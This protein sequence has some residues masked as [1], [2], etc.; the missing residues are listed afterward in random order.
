MG[1]PGSITYFMATARMYFPFFSG[2]VKCSADALDVANRQNAHGM[3]VAVRALVELFRSVK[4]EKELDR[5]DAAEKS[6]CYQPGVVASAQKN[7][8]M[9]NAA[10]KRPGSSG[11]P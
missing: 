4:R 6:R 11:R 10:S 2:E 5:P 3:T 9:G 8:S 7:N 1:D